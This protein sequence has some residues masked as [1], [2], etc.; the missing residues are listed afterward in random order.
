MQGA[1]MQRKQSRKSKMYLRLFFNCRNLCCIKEN[2][3][4][5]APLLSYVPLRE[6][7]TPNAALKNTNN[8]LTALM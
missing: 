8:S 4:S 1:F 7:N 5:Y 3:N 6:K 2:N